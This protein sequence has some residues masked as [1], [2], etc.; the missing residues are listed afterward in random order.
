[1]RSFKADYEPLHNQAANA[2][3]QAGF[4]PPTVIWRPVGEST[5]PIKS[6]D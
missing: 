3:A 1:M 4:D 5:N 6:N 2:L